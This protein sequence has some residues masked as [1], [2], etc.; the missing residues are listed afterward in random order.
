MAQQQSKADV[1]TWQRAEDALIGAVEYLAALPD[2]ERAFLSAGSRSAWPDIVRDMQSDYG[3]A[4][5]EPRRQLGRKEMAHLERMLLGERAAVLA[6][7]RQHRALLGK[8]LRM[9]RWPGAGGFGWEAVWEWAGG[10]RS[11]TTSDALRQRYSRAVGR[12]AA[13]MEVVV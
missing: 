9:K 11:G 2:R 10:H 5:A 6:V 8:V 3:D 13:A 7:P 4:E 12:V 1:V